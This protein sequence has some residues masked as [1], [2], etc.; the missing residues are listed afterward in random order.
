MKKD[1]Q[2]HLK[3]FWLLKMVNYSIHSTLAKRHHRRHF[4]WS[5]I[6]A[7]LYW[8][9]YTLF[10]ECLVPNIPLKL[11]DYIILFLAFI[12]I[13]TIYSVAMSTST[14]KK[15]LNSGEDDWLYNS[16]SDLSSDESGQVV[17]V[18]TFLS[19]VTSAF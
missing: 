7:W 4:F 5:L 6:S 1:S 13:K 9:P 14:F 19:L 12:F 16:S 18:L 2:F 17:N 11:L 8:W 15:C 3:E 10:P